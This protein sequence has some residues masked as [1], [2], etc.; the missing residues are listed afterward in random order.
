MTVALNGDGV[1]EL[2]AGYGR[3]MASRWVETWQRVP[4]PFWGW[5]AKA[6]D[7]MAGQAA[8]ARRPLARLARVMRAATAERSERYRHWVGVFD[9]ELLACLGGDLLPDID[10]V[11][12]EFAQTK[13]LDAVDSM[14]AVDTA[15]Y[16]PTD[17]LVKVDIAS[18]MHSLSLIHI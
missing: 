17:L 15:Y 13:D 6:A 18:M 2:F 5:F 4:V 16:L 14:L 10:P 7:R 3:H 8:D 1:D 9:P 12:S 11:R